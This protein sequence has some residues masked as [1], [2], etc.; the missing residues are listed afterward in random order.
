[1]RPNPKGHTF[2]PEAQ[3]AVG[4]GASPGHSRGSGRAANGPER[5]RT[6]VVQ[7]ASPT[8]TSEEM[9]GETEFS[10][11]LFLEMMV[12]QTETRTDVGLTGQ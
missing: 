6:G 3:E 1:M 8:H 9:E 2:Y 12:W 11:Q 7:R 4:G 5:R 10:L